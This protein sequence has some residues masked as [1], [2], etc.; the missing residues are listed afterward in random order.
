LKKKGEAPG[1]RGRK[2]LIE[3]STCRDQQGTGKNP[4]KGGKRGKPTHV[5]LGELQYE[6]RNLLEEGGGR[7]E[8]SR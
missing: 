4:K 7:E 3:R 2:D 8:N 5:F 6:G 1:R